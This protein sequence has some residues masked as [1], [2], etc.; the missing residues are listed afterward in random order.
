MINI[1]SISFNS[2]HSAIIANLKTSSNKATIVVSYKVGMGSDGNIESF[3]I[4]TKLFPSATADQLAATKD[5]PKL[6][7]YNYTTITQLGRCKVE[8]E[9]NT[10]CEKYIFFVVLG[11]REALLG[12]PDMELLNIRNIDC[13]TIGTEKRARVQIAM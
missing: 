5:A 6:R 10:K 8:I 1:N 12:I 3:N 2:N 13:N 4:F 9:N 11:D 7:T